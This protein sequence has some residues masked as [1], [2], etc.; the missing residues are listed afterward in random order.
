MS[1]QSAPGSIEQLSGAQFL[2]GRIAV[3]T[4]A[5]R[6]IG[7]ALAVALGAAGAKC[8][9]I[10]RTVGGLEECDDAIRAAGG[11]EAVLV[12]H[13]LM[14]HDGLDQL[15]ASLYDRFGKVDILAGCAAELGTLTPIGHIPPNLWKK[16]HDIN[17]T[18]NYRLIRSLDP[19]LK[20]SEGARALFLTDQITAANQ[21]YWGAYTTS[22]TALESLVLTYAAELA[23][24]PHRVNLASL[25]PVRTS[26]RATAFPGEKPE[27]LPTPEAIALP[28]VNLLSPSETRNGEIVKISPSS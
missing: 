13:D 7:R 2:K 15:G 25:P 27:T 20:R 4:G 12:P 19:L 10:A 24:T 16:V 23:R 22:K 14:N 11:E 17:V 5:S 9:L 8:V 3:V 21:A 26:L 18:A 6:G 1:D 28:C